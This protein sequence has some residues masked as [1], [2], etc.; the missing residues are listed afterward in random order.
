MEHL[1]TEGYLGHY[2]FNRYSVIATD[3]KA[4]NK[5][6]QETKVGKTQLLVSESF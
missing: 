1:I 5:Y 4:C 2:S 3:F 6:E